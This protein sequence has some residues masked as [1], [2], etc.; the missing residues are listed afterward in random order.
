[1]ELWGPSSSGLSGLRLAQ[2][3]VPGWAIKSQRRR[4][5]EDF[6]VPG[7]SPASKLSAEF[8]GRAS[9]GAGLVAISLPY[10]VRQ[11][12]APFNERVLPRMS[13]GVHLKLVSRKGYASLGG[14]ER[15]SREYGKV[16]L[17]QQ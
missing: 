1:M 7:R 17:N 4:A 16:A 10:R 3:S 15:C 8:C 11:T 6:R 12:D 2:P 9:V 14:W 5:R 13:L